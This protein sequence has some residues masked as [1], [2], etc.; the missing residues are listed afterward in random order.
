MGPPGPHPYLVG[1]S[2]GMNALDS[3]RAARNLPEAGAGSDFAVWG[4][5]QGGHASLF[6]GH[7]AASYAPDAQPGRCRRG[8][9]GP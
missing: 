2:E 7:L 9:A 8:R 4:H 3:V 1:T 5:S 6:T